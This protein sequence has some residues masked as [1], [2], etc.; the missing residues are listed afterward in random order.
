LPGRH[1]PGGVELLGERVQEQQR[2]SNFRGL[3]RV[4]KAEAL[5]VFRRQDKSLREG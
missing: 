5:T 1:A 3:G 4:E 2:I